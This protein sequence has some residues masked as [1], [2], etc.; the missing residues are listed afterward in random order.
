MD[1]LIVVIGVVFAG[2]LLLAWGVLKYGGRWFNSRQNKQASMASDALQGM[3]IF[4]DAQKLQSI[5]LGA[6]I[7]LPV[8]AWAI[9]G[10][11]VVVGCFVVADGSAKPSR[12]HMRDPSFVNLQALREMIVG[13]YIADMI[14]FKR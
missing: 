8:V 5:S 12:V 14:T 9:T 1:T 2:S 4:T 3:F 11:V 10:S 7:L 6:L 13:G